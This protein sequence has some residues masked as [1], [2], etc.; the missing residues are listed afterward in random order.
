[1]LAGEFLALTGNGKSDTREKLLDRGKKIGKALL[2]VTAKIAVDAIGHLGLGTNGLSTKIDTAIDAATGTAADEVEKLVKDLLQNYAADKQSIQGFKDVLTDFANEAADPIVIFLDE[3]DRC[4]PD[5]AVR[6]LERIKHFFDVPKVVFVLLINRAQLVA[7]IK[8]L[9][10]ARLDAEGYLA[11]FIQLQL[12]L[13]K[14]LRIG[15]GTDDNTLY[16]KRE[17]E[18][19]GFN[20]GTGAPSEFALVFGALSS[21]MALSLRD[22]E[23]AVTLYSFGQPLGVSA[24]YA[25]WPIMLK[26]KR[27]DLFRRAKAQ[28]PDAHAACETF[29]QKL[30]EQVGDESPASDVLRIFMDLHRCGKSSFAVNLA[31]DTEHILSGYFPTLHGARSFLS[32]VFDRVDLP[33]A[34]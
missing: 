17:L 27:P 22:I 26:I 6:T 34:R 19:Y 18:R 2:P 20:P 25:V 12:V 7:A 5:F 33:T 14:Q 31:P 29:A 32:F 15:H 30:Y 16:C 1:M 8:G 11:K 21:A 23:R 10:G 13:P 9:Y 24:R 3:L 4:R 28:V